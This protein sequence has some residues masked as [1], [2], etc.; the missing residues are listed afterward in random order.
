MTA[1]APVRFC[2][3]V[4]LAIALFEFALTGTA[5]AKAT[6]W[7][8]YLAPVSVCVG[9]TDRAASP[10]IQQGALTCLVNWARARHRQGRLSPSHSLQRA[11]VLK[12]HGVASCRQISH[13]PCGSDAADSLRR[14]GYTYA[15]FGENLFVGALG[16]VSARDVVS[17]WL[18]SP[19]H[20]ANI[21]QPG[22]R[23]VGA[24]LVRV[25]GIF[26]AGA[27]VVWIAAFASPR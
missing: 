10:R 1:A 14:S 6:S 2:V 27:A 16:S 20:R 23:N 25:D 4:F 17:A 22:F 19:A 15:S 26:Y 7:N 8:T 13:T 5:S 21:L 18:R 24:A 12:G 3:A 11:A 9:S